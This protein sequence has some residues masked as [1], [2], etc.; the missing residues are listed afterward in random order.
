M[1]TSPRQD[2]TKIQNARE[3]GEMYYSLKNRKN[4]NYRFVAF[5]AAFFTGFFAAFFT[6]FFTTFL[7]AFLTAFLAGFFFAGIIFF[8]YSIE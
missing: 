6:A 2:F 8:Y 4:E 5:L 1:E 3:T 7:V